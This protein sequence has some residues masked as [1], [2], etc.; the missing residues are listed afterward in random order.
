MRF[1]RFLL[2][3]ALAVAAVVSG[4]CGD[5][6]GTAETRVL[7]EQL[8]KGTVTGVVLRSGAPVVGGKVT[9]GDREV[10]TDAVGAYVLDGVAPGTYRLVAVDPGDDTPVCDAAG[11]CVSGRSSAQAVVEV[12]VPKAGGTV[13]VN[14]DL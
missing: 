1:P 3:S 6:T 12:V 11:A 9:L 2:V 4:A 8:V 14:V 5:N 10:V 13:T 7:G